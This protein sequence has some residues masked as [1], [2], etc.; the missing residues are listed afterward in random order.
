MMKNYE[1]DYPHIWDEEVRDDIEFRRFMRKVIAEMLPRAK[2]DMAAMENSR[3]PVSELLRILNEAWDV[4]EL[5][6]RAASP[7]QQRAHEDRLVPLWR[8]IRPLLNRTYEIAEGQ[9][10][11]RE[12]TQ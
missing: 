8:E 7:R 12:R 6:W 3:L 11:R 4:M 2:R 5:I 1:D 10:E 9:L